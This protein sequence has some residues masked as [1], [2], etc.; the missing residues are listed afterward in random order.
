[1]NPDAVTAPV[2]IHTRPRSNVV[3]RDAATTLATLFLLLGSAAAAHADAIIP[4]ENFDLLAPGFYGVG[5]S[6]GHF[7]ITVA[8]ST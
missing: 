2:S 3:D 8:P 6:I 1:M 7:N 5:S 4:Q